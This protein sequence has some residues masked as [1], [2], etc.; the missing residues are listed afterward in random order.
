MSNP[1]PTPT[2]PIMGDVEETYKGSNVFY[3]SFGGVPKADWTDREKSSAPVTDLC[4]RPIDPVAGQ[5][6]SIYRSKGLERKLSKK[7]K[8]SEFQREVMEHLVRYGLDTVSYLP[9][10][11]NDA[12]VFNVVSHH[13]R[14]TADLEKS[15]S[16]A[17]IIQGKF[18]KWDQKHDFEAKTFLMDSLSP[19]VK[20]GFVVA[21]R[22]SSDSFAA[23][24]LKLVYHLTTTSSKSYDVLKD[25]IRVLR[26]QQFSG[27]DI[28]ALSM[29][30]ITVAEE[31]E[32]AGFYDH[33]LTL[34]MVDGFLCA[35]RDTKG[36]FHF[37]MNTLRAKVSSLIQ[38]TV[39]LDSIAQSEEFGKKHLSYRDVC[40]EAVREYRDLKHLN[41]WEPGKLPKDRQAP[42]A[43]SL[44]VTAAQVLNLVESMA[45][46][47][48]RSGSSGNKLRSNKSGKR[49]YNCGGTGHLAKDCPEPKLSSEEAKVKRHGSMAKWRLTPPKH[50][51][52]HEKSV[53]GRDFKWC[54]KCGNW[55]TTHDTSTH[56]GK[57]AVGEHKSHSKSKRNVPEANL[58]AWDPS[59]WVVLV[60]QNSDPNRMQRCYN[61]YVGVSTMIF[62][63]WILGFPPPTFHGVWNS[64]MQVQQGVLSGV[65]HVCQSASA[66]WIQ[67]G[68]LSGVSHVCQSASAFWIEYKDVLL[69]LLSPAMWMLL[70]F[71]IGYLHFGLHY[72]SNEELIVSRMVKGIGRSKMKCSNVTSAFDTSGP[73]FEPQIAWKRNGTKFKSRVVLRGNKRQNRS[74]NHR[75]RPSAPPLPPGHFIKF[76]STRMP[77]HSPSALPF[78][79]VPSHAPTDIPSSWNQRHKPSRTPSAPPFRRVP[80]HAPS[81]IPRRHPTS[82]STST[83][84]RRSHQALIITSVKDA[85]KASLQSPTLFKSAVDYSSHPSSSASSSFPI[86]WDSGASVCVTP[87]RNDFITYNSTP[88]IPSVKGMGGKP[89]AVVGEGEVV[90][91]MHDAEGRLRNL[92]LKAYHIP[93]ST[94]RL[95]STNVVLNQH[96]DET[97]T[98]NATSLSLSGT[99]SDPSRGKIIIYNNPVNN[100]P[101]ST[102]YLPGSIEA[103][104]QELFNVVSSVHES[105]INLTEAQKELLR[106]HQRLGHLSF[107]KVQHLLRSGA[108]SNTVASR[109]LHT[110]ASK[111]K[112]PPKCAACIFG[113]QVT[114][115]SPGSTTSVV[116]DRAGVLRA[117]NL[118]PGQEVSVDHFVSSVKGRTIEGFDKGSDGQRYCGGC[119]FVDHCSSYVHAE[120]QKS[121]SSHDTLRAKMNF[122]AIC[123]D[124]G[125]TAQTFSSDNGKA[126]TSREFTEHL[127]NFFQISKFAGVGAH[128]HNAQAER[129]IRSIMSIARTMMLH[130]GIHWP[131][132]ADPTLWPLAV[133]H[134]VFLF[135]HVPSE[136]TGLSPND[137]FTRTRW[138]HKRFHDI[139]VWGCPLYVLQKSLQDGKKIP[140]WKPRSNRCV[141]MGLSPSHATT[142]P[143]ALNLS[144]GSITPQFHVVF[145]DWFAT[146]G[147]SSSQSPDFSSD[148]WSRMFGQSRFQYV[149]DEE[150]EASAVDVGDAAA[151]ASSAARSDLID[152]AQSV[153]DHSFRLQEGSSTVPMKTPTGIPSPSS[154]PTDT[155][156]PSSSPT[157]IPSPS[158]SPTGIPSPSSSPT[159]IPS[160]SSSP[161]GIPSPSSSPTGI[162]LSSSSPSDVPYSISRSRGSSSMSRPKRSPK[163]VQRLTYNHGSRTSKY[164][165]TTTSSSATYFMSWDF[166]PLPDATIL[167]A[168]KAKDN[169]DVL[170]YDEAMADE[171]K[172]EWIKAA[173]KEI[174]SLEELGCW[175]EI[176]QSK[177]TS[178]IIP[179]TWV[180][181]VKRAPD[182]SF[183]KFKARYCLRGDLQEGEFDTYAPVVHFTSVRLFLAWSLMFG[184]KTCTID[185]SNAFIQAELKEPT[186]IHLPRGFNSRR[187]SKTCLR[188]R[189][190]LYGLSVAPRL[191]YE[192]LFKALKEE[193]L[194]PSKQDP[195]LLF[196]SDLIAIVHVDDLGLQ[197]AEEVTAEALISNLEKKG[198]TLTR[199]GSFT[200][201]LG[202]QYRSRSDGSVEMSQSGLIQK[203]LEATSMEDCKPNLTPCKKECLGM[204][205]DGKVF[206]E[207]WNY[208]SVVGMLLYLSTNTRPDISFAVSQVARFTHTPKQ[209]HGTAVKSIIRYLAGTSKRGVI[210]RRPDVH[211]LLLLIA[212]L[213][214]ITLVF[215]APQN[216]SKVQL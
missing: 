70:G 110:A 200:E 81:G 72:V 204:D 65:S 118:H 4:Y 49:C 160:P 131:D 182:G 20:D 92:K 84:R 23:T 187:G 89:A 175:E 177:A 5:K 130:S 154:S 145:D 108:L 1:T 7:S 6:G 167:S 192:H 19:D 153:S 150:E 105:N 77:S 129:A 210:Y 18:D 54:G 31:L 170:T 209:S 148:A 157:G 174:R 134:A 107:R 22:E 59:A 13:A 125:V 109:S 171:H 16:L 87:S 181:R 96:P 162:P 30:Y 142:V 190:S 34:S 124:S 74:R 201:Y 213:M 106:W 139:H 99:P 75:P 8:L 62:L 119:L 91:L 159:G 169:P 155:P 176:N 80:S 172:E 113:K 90:W 137:I 46:N 207:T 48:R 44:N 26:P 94:T 14:F 211:P 2:K 116:H 24:W 161:A 173:M 121:L 206:E 55:T 85:L 58:A 42:P 73:D 21:V 133:L 127:S 216:Q 104:S 40:A 67:Q 86:V 208:R 195:C 98:L 56:T 205:P 198:F 66:F 215:T 47:S 189:R 50:G 101:T 36:T 27:Q 68:V 143:L 71:G 15:I 111:I 17:K 202:I 95:I 93:S 61:F 199:E 163:P 194:V 38:S 132:V 57:S 11:K 79:R 123:R 69:S 43:S 168:A 53:N 184:W 3:Y 52:K 12:K 115:V 114:R 117:D 178:K 37:S 214:R 196:R 25:K 64:A 9:D 156:S 141:H 138:P 63:V 78:R 193:G 203:I 45:E 126:F 151:A 102:A 122:E 120:L 35:S 144:T 60:D 164:S 191:W 147:S 149:V 136:V 140:R 29:E 180:F 76:N 158:S 152:T 32:N 186:F 82:S 166:A 103:P 179:G 212:M 185:F 33:S 51:E 165:T 83:Q 10:P 97:I 28:E 188:L 39:F 183:K 135:N 197:F 112:S 128:H 41:L 146:V 88:C 100:L